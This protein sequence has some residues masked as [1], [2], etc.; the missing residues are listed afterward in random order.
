MIGIT[1]LIKDKKSFSDR[2]RYGHDSSS[3]KFEK[4]GKFIPVVVFNITSMCN[5]SCKHCYYSAKS[6]PDED[7]L[8]TNEILNIIDDI[9]NLGVPVILVSGGEPL[10]KKG[11]YELISFMREK[12]ID[13]GLSTN[14]TLI[15]EKNIEKIKKSGANYVGISIDGFEK[16]HDF[17]RGKKGAFRRSE[18]AIEICLKEGLTVSVRLTL[19]KFNMNEITK[20]LEWAEEKG[21]QRFCIYH[22]VASGR[23]KDIKDSALTP[24]ETRKTIEKV[25]EMTKK[26]NMEILTVDAPFDGFFVA[27]KKLEEGDI[28]SA[29]RIIK[30]LKEQGGDGTG[31]KIAVI[32]HRGDVY[33]SQFWLTD[34][35]GN[36]REKNFSEIWNNSESPFL[37]Y[38]RYRVREE[39][40]GKCGNCP[41]R[42]ICG[43][44]RPRAISY[45]GKINAQDP[46]CYITEEEK[47]TL[48]SLLMEQ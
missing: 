31:K 37:Y 18:E 32:S 21:V 23:G 13:V 24:E 40:E 36:V 46:L 16:T 38:L 11:V 14:G 44:F 30:L 5:L 25:Y 10:M 43:G 12:N 29:K 22:L 26:L 20:I 1:R 9:G 34:S 45:Y 17:F 15:T 39:L 4:D 2:L 28:D 35:L 6:Y 3:H 41:L 42:E 27:L 33:I 47:T 19:T 8:S 7:E 48:S